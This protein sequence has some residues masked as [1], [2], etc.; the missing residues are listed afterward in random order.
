MFIWGDRWELLIAIA[1]EDRG[2][3]EFLKVPLTSTPIKTK[4]PPYF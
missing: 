3:A 1:L 4:G 2:V